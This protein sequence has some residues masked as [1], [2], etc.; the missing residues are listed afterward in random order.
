[1]EFVPFW[2]SMAGLTLTPAQ[3]QEAGVGKAAFDAM[4]LLQRPGFGFSIPLKSYASCYGK[5]IIDASPLEPNKQDEIVFR[6][7]DGAKQKI[8]TLEL[9]NWLNQLDA[10]EIIVNDKLY[11]IKT[12]SKLVTIA[13]AKVKYLISDEPAAN[14]IQ[15]I[16]MIGLNPV[17]NILDEGFAQDYQVLDRGCDCTTCK[18]G[19]TRSYL[20]HLLQHTPLL[21]QRFL[22]QHNVWQACNYTNK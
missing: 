3:W 4:A 10:D 22:V 11:L 21:A 8:S 18:L 17:F 19:F 20:H 1:M 13:E 5:V 7:P 6:T 16:V 15:G 14:G 12:N 2:N 9:E